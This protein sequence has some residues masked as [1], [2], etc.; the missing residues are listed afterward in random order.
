M[1]HQATANRW[2]LS[3]HYG[4]CCRVYLVFRAPTFALQQD[5][6]FVTYG[7]T[8]T[9]CE[10][11]DHLFGRGLVGQKEEEKK[12]PETAIFRAKLL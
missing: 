3:S 12:K 8:D 1:T 2:S 11:S 5:F 9:M 6:V 4:V 7:R 10:N